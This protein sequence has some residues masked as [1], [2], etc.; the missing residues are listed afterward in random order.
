MDV[1]KT[2][3]AL[4]SAG[5]MLAGC[6]SAAENLA[7]EAIESETGAEVDID[8]DSI[9]IESD[10]GTIE[11][12]S[13]DDGVS[14]SGT[15]DDGEDITIEMGGTEVPA[16]FPMPIY[17]PSE[18]THVSSFDMGSA[19][20]YSVTLEIEPGDAADAVTFY[21]DWYESEQMNMSSSDTMV[22][23]EGDGITSMVQVA[24]YGSYSEV[25]LTWTP[26]S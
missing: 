14:I 19:V 4:A 8:D 9:V 25:V 15:G 6:G 16:D 12:D 21:R 10:D 13:S 17:T 23:G 18:V 24:D 20:S 11:I 22:I 7:E 5:L 3:I 26:N 2:L 1:R